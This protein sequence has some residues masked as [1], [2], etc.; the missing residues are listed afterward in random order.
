MP[1]TWSLAV[2]ILVMSFW[3]PA[4]PL[5]VAQPAAGQ[6]NANQ[7]QMSSESLSPQAQAELVKKIQRAL[8]T[9]PNFG[10][11]DNIAFRLQGRTVI[12]EGQV[13]DP[14]NKPDAEKAVQ[15]IEGV[16]KVVNKIDVLP[17]GQLDNRIRR[18]VY[19][20]IYNYGPFFKYKNNQVNPPIRIIVQNAN[21]TLYGVVDTEA[22]K[23]V[24]TLRVKQ[25]S[26]VLGVTN[27]LRV[28]KP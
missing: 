7:S 23:N 16:D 18:Q 11:F 9:L 15:K 14:V 17:P 27:N 8:I 13:T 2:I 22:D 6:N 26:D 5:S 3:V 19:D 4:Q 20:A 1:K 25:V 21:V 28:V 24:A 10:V 12:L